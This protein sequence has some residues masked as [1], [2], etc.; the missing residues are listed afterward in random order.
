[1]PAVDID[2]TD[3]TASMRGKLRIVTQMGNIFT[4]SQRGVH[5]GIAIIEWNGF[6]I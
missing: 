1:L 6:S 2:D 3:S 5:D 4:G